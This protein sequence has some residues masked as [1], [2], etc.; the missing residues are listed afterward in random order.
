MKLNV[1]FVLDVG[2]LIKEKESCNYNFNT[3]YH[4]LLIKNFDNEF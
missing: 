1:E 4:K 2:M 3:F